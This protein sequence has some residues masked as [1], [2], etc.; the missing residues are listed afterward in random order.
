MEYIACAVGRLG[1]VHWALLD[2]MGHC[3][4]LLGALYETDVLFED[5]I[6]KQRKGYF[7]EVSGDRNNEWSLCEGLLIQLYQL[8]DAS[9]HS[10]PITGLH[11]EPFPSSSSKC[12]V[13]VTTPKR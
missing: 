12:F 10:D 13:M 5:S 6:L 3:S 4:L 2:L 8:Y 7:H 11:C 9:E 1:C